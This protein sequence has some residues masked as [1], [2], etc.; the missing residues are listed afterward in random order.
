MTVVAWG[1][2]M[3]QLITS[4]ATFALYSATLGFKVKLLF[5]ASKN[6]SVTADN[7]YRTQVMITLE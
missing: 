5:F 6:A 7:M 4:E 2:K 3:P 1:P